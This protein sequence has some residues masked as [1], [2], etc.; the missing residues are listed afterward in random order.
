MSAEEEA[1]FTLLL[2]TFDTVL[3]P[4]GVLLYLS[5]E[6]ATLLRRVRQRG[7][8]YERDIHLDYLSALQ[9]EYERW[10]QAYDRS[11][12]IR[13]ENTAAKAIAEQISACL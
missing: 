3:P 9:E 8:P 11:P 6:P 7:R 10:F 1:T 5:A 2:R 13:V 12:K 4:P